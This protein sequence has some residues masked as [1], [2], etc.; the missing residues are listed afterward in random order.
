MYF[1]NV[2]VFLFS[3]VKSGSYLIK[4]LLILNWNFFEHFSQ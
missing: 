3:T 2:N 1:K 4:G